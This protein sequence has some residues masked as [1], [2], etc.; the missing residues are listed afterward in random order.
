MWVQLTPI[1][2]NQKTGPIPVSTT[3]EKSCPT[4]CPLK[5]TNCY[6][7]L[8]PLGLHWRAVSAQKRGGNWAAFCER[9]KKFPRGQLWRHNQAGDLPGKRNRLNKTMCLQLA[10]ANKGRRGFTYTHYR[11]TAHNLP[12]IR[13]MNEE[14]F[15]VNL[16]ADNLTYADAYAKMGLPTVVILPMDTVAPVRTPEGR[17]VVI[18]PAQTQDNV[19]CSTCQLCQVSKRKSIVGFLAHGTVAKRLSEKLRWL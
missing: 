8:G 18:C 16:S 19:S 17:T 6:A 2:H 4:T 15:T 1:S 3:E 11:P 12:I 10:N 13:Q 9:V 14:G 5:G 7:G